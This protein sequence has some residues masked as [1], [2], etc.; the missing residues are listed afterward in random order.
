MFKLNKNYEVVRRIL[1]CDYIR[2]SPAET[3]SRNTPNSQ[4]YIK[5]P[6]EGSVTSL[7]NSYLDSNFE[8]IEKADNPK[9]AYGNDIKLVNLGPIALIGIFKLTT[10]SGIHLKEESCAHIVYLMHNLITTS[11]SGNDLSTGFDRDRDR[12]RNQLSKKK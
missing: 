10:F 12:R 3:S 5:I 6:R 8:L 7:L 4:I 1:K 9:Y 11:K 2:Y